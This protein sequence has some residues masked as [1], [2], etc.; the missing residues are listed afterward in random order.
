VPLSQ[1]IRAIILTKQNLWEFLKR[2]AIVDSPVEVFGAQE[3]LQLLDQFFD[4]A[5]YY[6]SLGYEQVSAGHTEH[7]LLAAGK[8]H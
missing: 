8:A 1:L 4:C 3:L 6:A 2:E 7:D 5:I